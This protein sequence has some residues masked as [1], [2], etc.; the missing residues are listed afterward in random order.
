M[1]IWQQTIRY[2]AMLKPAQLAF[3]GSLVQHGLVFA[4]DV[5]SDLY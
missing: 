3:T 1:L 5:Y 4:S 2:H